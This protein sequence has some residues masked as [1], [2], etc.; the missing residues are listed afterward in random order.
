MGG[1]REPAQE[2]QEAFRRANDGIAAR[3]RELDVDDRT[4]FLC[5]CSDVRCTQILQ[6]TLEEYGAV[7]SDDGR[8][9]IAPGH[10]HG[11]DEH[12]LEQSDGYWVTEKDGDGVRHT[13]TSA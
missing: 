2:S 10:P 8:F 5:E 1:P 7:R 4:P 12:V 11:D 3:A 9:M 6:L 13:P